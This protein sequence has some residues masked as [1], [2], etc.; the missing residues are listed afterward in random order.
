MNTE[1]KENTCLKILISDDHPLF[2]D[3]IRGVLHPL[4]NDVIILE[5]KNFPETFKAVEQNPDFDLVLLDL[6]MPG[7]N[8]LEAIS[9]LQS[10][11]P[12][13]PIVVL[14]ASEDPTLV[15]ETLRRG[16]MGYLPKTVVPD[17]LIYGLKVVLAGE[18][19]VPPKFLLDHPTQQDRPENSKNSEK[20]I[21][22]SL[23]PRQTHVLK[24]LKKGMSNKEIASSVGMS[25][26]TVK[27]HVAAILRTFKV[28]NRTQA[29][30][31]G[32]KMGIL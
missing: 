24:L 2:R 5:T 30:F 29:V 13:I 23:T 6:S 14:S 21:R 32:E 19:F 4:G 18:L 25:P 11:H 31:V 27:V 22:V 1:H 28:H 3:A 15:R 12:A 8:G 17:I 7:M 10:Q 26:S 9:L 16:A 20:N